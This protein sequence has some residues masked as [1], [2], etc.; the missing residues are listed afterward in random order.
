MPGRI[1][2]AWK[3]A[4]LLRERRFRQGGLDLEFPEIRVKLDEQGR[5][6]D[7]VVSEYDASHQ[8]IEECMLATNEAVAEEL[9][10]RGSP[11]IYR[12]HE[13]PAEERLLEF[14]ELVRA[15][16]FKVGDLSDRAEA[17]RLLD[18]VKGH[19]AE[20]AIKIGFLKS[21]KR[22]DYRTDPAG[23]YGLAKRDYTCL[24]YTSDAADE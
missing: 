22:A 19:P 17:Q 11:C 6:I 16:G 24:L 20:Q 10:K 1:R 14:R 13:D 2:E 23:H 18:K 5:P 12:V 15:A 8:L 21:L 7:L 3:L 9:R 4:S